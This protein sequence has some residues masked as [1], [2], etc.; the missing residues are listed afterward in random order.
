[1]VWCGKRAQ[2]DGR[3]DSCLDTTTPIGCLNTY[4]MPIITKTKKKKSGEIVFYRRNSYLEASGDAPIARVT[5][6][7]NPREGSRSVTS[8]LIPGSAGLTRTAYS[9]V[10]ASCAREIIQ[11]RIEENIMC[12]ASIFLGCLHDGAAVA[13]TQVRTQCPPSITSYS[14]RLLLR[15]PPAPGILAPTACKRTG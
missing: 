7:V 1:M 6:C 11:I 14:L 8:L 13:R 4:R 10:P 3:Y 2:R 9:T 5:G 15:K 12:H